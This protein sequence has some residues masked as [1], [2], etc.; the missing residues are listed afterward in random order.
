MF[1]ILILLNNKN[2]K[3]ASLEFRNSIGPPCI[4]VWKMV[5]LETNKDVV[6]KIG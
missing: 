2:I 1:N 3:T 6:T 4:G 5:I